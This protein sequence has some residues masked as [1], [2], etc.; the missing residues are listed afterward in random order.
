ML[1]PVLWYAT[2][3]SVGILLHEGAHAA[4]GYAQGASATLYNFWVDFTATEHQIAIARFAGPAFSLV[5]GA[6]AT[7]WWR[8]CRNSTAGLPLAFLA[9]FGLSGFF[10]NLMSASFVGD[11][12]GVA[13]ELAVPIP[14][15][16]VAS[17]IGAIGLA[18]IE[19]AL[20]RELHRS[21]PADT[22]RIAAT[23]GVVIVPVVAGTVLV[24]LVNYPTPLTGFAAA[25]IGEA[26]FAHLRGARSV[27]G[28]SRDTR[29]RRVRMALG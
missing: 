7:V 24:L 20:G 5:V 11:F 26:S 27:H 14:A 12:S 10:G 3:Y 19:F 15:R 29:C 25:R 22:S 21:A 4:A 16:Y 17:V 6:I 28:A 13:R 18:T 23:F 8:R 1:R 2:A 9:A